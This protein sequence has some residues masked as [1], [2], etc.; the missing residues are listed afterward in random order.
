MSNHLEDL[1]M[2]EIIDETGENTWTE[3]GKRVVF[4][5][6]EEAL[7]ELQEYFDNL[8]EN[9]IEFDL[10]NYSVREESP[11]GEW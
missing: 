4:D 5:T 8:I 2:W 6:R 1:V 11:L 3:S 10:E 9:G 7:K